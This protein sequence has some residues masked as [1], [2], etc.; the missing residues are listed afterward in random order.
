MRL[1]SGVRVLVLCK[2]CRVYP[3]GNREPLNNPE[4]RVIQ[5]GVHWRMRIQGAAQAEWS[6]NGGEEMGK[7]V[8]KGE[9]PALCSGSGNGK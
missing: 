4:Q 5:S 7:E 9:S 1:E 8:R 6:K 2:V 3:A